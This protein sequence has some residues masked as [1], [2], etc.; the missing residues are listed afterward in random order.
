MREMGRKEDGT[1]HE[2]LLPG[3]LHPR[4]GQPNAC[5]CP[6]TVFH[7]SDTDI[8]GTDISG[9]DFHIS[10]T[11]GIENHQNPLLTTSLTAVS[12]GKLVDVTALSFDGNQLCG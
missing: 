4:P 12:E 8:S 7:I 5:I 6:Y 9:I 1:S 3:G 10:G 11:N 2:Y